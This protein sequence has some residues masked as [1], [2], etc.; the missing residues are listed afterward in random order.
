MRR[1]VVKISIILLTFVFLTVGCNENR[2]PVEPTL[3][4]ENV[5]AKKGF[6][7]GLVVNID[8]EDY[9]FAGAPDGP[10]G[11]V[12]V[13]GHYWVKAGKNQVVGKHYNSGP[14]GASKWWSSDA[15]DGEYLYKVHGIIDTWS[16]EKSVSYAKRGYVHRHEFVR[17]SDGEFH[18]NKVVC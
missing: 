14:F 12:D 1:Y 4:P 18:P 7:H 11:E 17:V 2:N 3:Q 8:G 9:Y 13:P 6:V 16:L 5:L 15:P 10:N